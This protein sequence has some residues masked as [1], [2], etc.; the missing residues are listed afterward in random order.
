MG[1]N[2]KSTRSEGVD[3]KNG[4]FF[5]T[6]CTENMNC[7][8]SVIEPQKINP[9][10]L[11]AGMYTEEAI[12]FINENDEGVCIH[13]YVIMPNHVH[14]IVTVENTDVRNVVKRI[15][16]YSAKKTGASVW[17]RSFHDHKVR[18]D[19]DGRDIQRY[20]RNNPL[21]WTLDKYYIVGP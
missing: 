11:P 18:G 21:K 12:K 10:L 4:T 19:V 9:V 13:D 15:K 5:I 7:I 20:I 14:F 16:T 1:G 3:Y 2:R 17:Q 6:F 8:L